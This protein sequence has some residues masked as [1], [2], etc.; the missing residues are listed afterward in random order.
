MESESSEPQQQE[1]Q[2]ASRAWSSSLHVRDREAAPSTAQ[3]PGSTAV[4][5]VFLKQVPFN[6]VQ[7]GQERLATGEG[8]NHMQ[9]YI[10]VLNL[11]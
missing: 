8:R 10:L 6:R 1:P 5:C 9:N 2:A 4:P 3:A 11:G 7:G